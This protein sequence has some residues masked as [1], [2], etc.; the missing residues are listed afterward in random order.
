MQSL[1]LFDKSW[2][3]DDKCELGV[4]CNQSIDIEKDLTENVFFYYEIR[5]FYQNH[6]RYFKSKSNEQLRG[7]DL[8]L[9]KVNSDCDPVVKNKDLWRTI[10][11]GNNNLD[12]EGV[13]FPCGM[14]A[15]S[16]FNGKSILLTLDTF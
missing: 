9:A 15:R 4:I 7:N 12:P 8:D 16:I 3:Y 2:R 6:R 5:N 11:I 1:S 10:S 14:M 13:A